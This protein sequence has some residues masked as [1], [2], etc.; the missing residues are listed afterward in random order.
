MTTSV[1]IGSID[2]LKED[3]ENAWAD[4]APVYC[5]VQAGGVCLQ[6]DFIATATSGGVTLEGEGIELS[7]EEETIASIEFDAS[8]DINTY[9]LYQNNGVLCIIAFL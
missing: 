8:D 4:E 2:K 1:H 5:K 6:S 7:I 9:T 3:I